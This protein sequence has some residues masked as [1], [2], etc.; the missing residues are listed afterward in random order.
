MKF[1]DGTKEYYGIFE[2]HYDDKGE[3]WGR[4]EEPAV[5][6]VVD[7]TWDEED[8]KELL[9]KVVSMILNDIT[10]SPILNEPESWQRDERDYDKTCPKC[11]EPLTIEPCDQLPY[12]FCPKCELYVEEVKDEEPDL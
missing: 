9:I 12:W 4:D 11:D 6:F 2:V 8:P 1:K 3:L 5:K 7:P 10:I